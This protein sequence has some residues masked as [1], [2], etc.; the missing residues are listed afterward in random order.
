M[1]SCNG[2]EKN[3]TEILELTF[4]YIDTSPATAS[5]INEHS[6]TLPMAPY[7]KTKL[8]TYF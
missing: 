1:I 7:F 5:A 3:H 8:K 6:Q 2:S 4:L